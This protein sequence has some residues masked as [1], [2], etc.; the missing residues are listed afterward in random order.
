MNPRAQCGAALIFLLAA[1]ASARPAPPASPPSPRTYTRF[2]T[3][4]GLARNNRNPFNRSTVIAYG[5]PERA[6]VSVRIYNLIGQLVRTFVD[7]VEEAGYRSVTFPAE[8]LP[9]GMYF[10]RLDAVTLDAPKHAFSDSR[11]LML[12]K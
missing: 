10:Y 2:T 9:G 1:S 5:L 3:N 6:R 8:G 12:V 7:A 4:D 11:K